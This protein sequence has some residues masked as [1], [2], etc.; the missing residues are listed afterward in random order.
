MVRVMCFFSYS[1]SGH[2]LSAAVSSSSSSKSDIWDGSLIRSGEDWRHTFRVGKLVFAV[3]VKNHFR[4][5]SSLWMWFAIPRA[6]F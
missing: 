6:Q 1:H 5:E 4:P 2:F 3:F